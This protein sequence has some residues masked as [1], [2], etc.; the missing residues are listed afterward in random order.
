MKG[1]AVEPEPEPEL[2]PELAFFY[3]PPSVGGAAAARVGSAAAGEARAALAPGWRV[4]F[5]GGANRRWG[6]SVATLQRRDDGTSSGSAASPPPLRL[7]TAVL[8]GRQRPRAQLWTR[9]GETG[10]P[11]HGFVLS[12]ALPEL[13]ALERRQCRDGGVTRERVS[14]LARTA[15][16]RSFEPCE[17]VAWRCGA[18][19]T[20]CLP[21][22]VV[23]GLRN[24]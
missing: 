22:Y 1:E 13:D 12:L 21:A 3:A 6:C 18:P 5:G 23:S 14:L 11:A 20:A 24:S 9:E 4:V 17:A 15:D 19:L 16:G 8:T 7:C 10:A 2:E